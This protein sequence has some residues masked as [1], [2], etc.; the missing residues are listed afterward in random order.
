MF[1]IVL[2]FLISIVHFY[3]NRPKIE[4]KPTSSTITLPGQFTANFPIQGESAI[5]TDNFGVIASSPDQSPVPIASVTKVMTAYLILKAHPLQAGEEGPTL[6]I[7]AQD[8]AEYLNDE[9]QDYSVLKVGEGEKLTEKQLLEGLMLPSAD[10]IA[11]FLARWDAGSESAFVEKMNET[12]QSLDMTQTHYEDASGVSSATISNAIDQIKIS[13]VAMK[14]PVFREIVAMQQVNFPVAGIV[15]NV[16]NLLGTHGIVGIKTG[17]T[18]EACGC[19]ISATPIDIGE[20]AHYIIGVVLG[21]R[22]NHPLHSAL[23]ESAIMLDEVRSEFKLYP[24]TPQTTGFGEVI[25]A[26]HSNSSLYSS[27]PIQILGYPGMTA[28]LSIKLLE[29]KLPIPSGENMASLRIQ[30]GQSVQ[31]FPLQNSEQINPPSILWRFFRN[32]I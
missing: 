26:W 25:N 31:E 30:A 2:I 13:Q 7:T 22:A 1:A 21:Q 6:T 27:E 8:V 12:A 16:N 17:S 10:N 29:T 9:A 5:G 24:L 3:N 15:R 32:W 14:D 4:A 20:E 28:S 19:F 11:S 23:N 18:M